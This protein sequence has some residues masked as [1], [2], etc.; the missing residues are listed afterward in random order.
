MANEQLPI[1]LQI[2]QLN[3]FIESHGNAK[4]REK[5]I[6]RNIKKRINR[7]INIYQRKR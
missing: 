2:C 3:N 6:N 1:T 5:R 7:N 4:A